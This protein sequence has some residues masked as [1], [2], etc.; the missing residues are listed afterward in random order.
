ML[1]A[2]FLQV[3]PEKRAHLN[4]AVG[5]ALDLSQPLLVEFSVIHDSGSNT[6]SVDRRVRVEGADEDLD[7][8]LHALLLLCVLANKREGTNAFTIESL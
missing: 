7:L 4:D 8:R 6:G 1:A 2:E 3:L 5:H